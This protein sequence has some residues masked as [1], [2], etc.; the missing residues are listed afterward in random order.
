MS[1]YK[2]YVINSPE[3]LWVYSLTV[4]KLKP[5]VIEFTTD[6]TK[7]CYLVEDQFKYVRQVTDN[8]IVIVT[9][10]V[11]YTDYIVID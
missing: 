11:Y 9:E 1:Y 10:G 8:T 7:A 4:Y 3:N 6:A 5:T 2:A